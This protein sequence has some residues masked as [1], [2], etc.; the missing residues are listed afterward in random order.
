LLEES[1]RYFGY[2]PRQCLEASSSVANLKAKKSELE[3]AIK[4]GTRNKSVD[5]MVQMMQS[6]R[7]GGPDV[8]Y[9]IYQILPSTAD[10]KQLLSDCDFDVVSKWSFNL[11]M[12][13]LEETVEA[14]Y[15]QLR[16]RAYAQWCPRSNR[17]S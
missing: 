5:D 12:D 15:K 14:P 8:S 11:F 4:H 10:K 9:M 6:T 13:Q 16:E 1:T 3:S 2:N 7:T 17:L